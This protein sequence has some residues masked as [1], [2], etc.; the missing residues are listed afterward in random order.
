MMLKIT[1]LGY[2][3]AVSDEVECDMHRRYHI[4]RLLVVYVAVRHFHLLVVAR[5]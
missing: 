4:S 2:E 3:L 1:L 5:H